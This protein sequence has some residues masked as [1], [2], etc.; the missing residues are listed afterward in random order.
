LAL[1]RS[2]KAFTLRPQLGHTHLQT[3]LILAA[4]I[5]V[6]VSDRSAAGELTGGAELASVYDTILDAH[7]DQVDA[8]LAR[9]C[10]PA[11]AEACAS[12]RVVA[13]WW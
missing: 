10:P 8:Q 2:A 3:A 13:A 12:M 9:A 1:R 7:F 4:I 6:G 11:P 5:F